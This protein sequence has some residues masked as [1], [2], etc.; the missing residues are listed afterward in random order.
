VT[1]DF[2]QADAT[3]RIPAAPGEPG[4]GT[5]S[6]DELREQFTTGDE[7]HTSRDRVGGVDTEDSGDFGRTDEFGAPSDE[8]M[9][10]NVSDDMADLHE[11]RSGERRGIIPARETTE[12]GGDH[13]HLGISGD[14]DEADATQ[15][16]PAEPVADENRS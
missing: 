14:F 4:S 2:G 16:V 12:P 11:G 13:E 6:G 7:G 9:G 5:E 15:T 8:V 3:E 10:T 1:G